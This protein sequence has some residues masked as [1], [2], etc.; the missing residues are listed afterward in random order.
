MPSGVRTGCKAASAC[1]APVMPATAHATWSSSLYI[2]SRLTPT[3]LVSRSCTCASA[4]VQSSSSYCCCKQACSV[5]HLG[6]DLL[7]CSQDDPVL[8]THTQG[9][10]CIA[11]GLHGVL[12]L[13]EAPLWAEDGGSGVIPPGHVLGCTAVNSRYSQPHTLM[14]HTCRCSALLERQTT[15][16][17]LRTSKL[18][19]ALSRLALRVSTDRDP[20]TEPGLPAVATNHPSPAD[21][22][23][24]TPRPPVGHAPPLERPTAMASSGSD[25]EHDSLSDE[26]SSSSSSH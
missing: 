18:L 8:G 9:C 7:L 21:T 4:S 19:R 24:I 12:H 6:G 14:A 16:Y 11:D 10:A 26:V 25:S 15:D 13:E 3:A 1:S 5:L 17:R 2:F 23:L 20:F 22:A